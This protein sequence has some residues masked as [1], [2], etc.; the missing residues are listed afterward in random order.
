MGSPR[1][2]NHREQRCEVA[3]DSGDAV[4]EQDRRAILGA[5]QKPEVG[6]ARVDEAFGEHAF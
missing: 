6:F 2:R 3:P 5:A 1:A 4:Q